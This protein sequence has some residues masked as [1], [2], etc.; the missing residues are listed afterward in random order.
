MTWETS[1]WKT[2]DEFYKAIKLVASLGIDTKEF[3]DK[4]YE[5]YL[6]SYE[7]NKK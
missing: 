5:C 6:L 7:S 3:K 1:Y 4:H 2:M